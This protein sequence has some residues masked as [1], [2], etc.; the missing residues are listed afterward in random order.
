MQL[1]ICKYAD[2][3][4]QENQDQYEN[5]FSC[6]SWYSK[7]ANL[8]VHENQDQNEKPFNHTGAKDDLN[9]EGCAK[10]FAMFCFDF[11]RWIGS[12]L[13]SGFRVGAL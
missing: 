5:P 9:V 13:L 6:S 11:L 1:S 12:A 3:K 8:K 7:S 10:S 2:L 4:I